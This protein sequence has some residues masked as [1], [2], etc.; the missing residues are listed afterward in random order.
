M[1]ARHFLRFLL[2][3]ALAFSGSAAQLHALAHA[4]ADLVAAASDPAPKAPAPLKHSS[5]QCLVVHALDGTAA[6][7]SNFLLTTD[8]SHQI[9]PVAEVRSGE[10]PAAAFQSRAP[11]FLS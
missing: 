3:F 5:D 7:G 4:Q 6:D 8:A 10:S 1:K 11:P 9:L 2:A